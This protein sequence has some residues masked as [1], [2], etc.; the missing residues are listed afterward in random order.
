VTGAGTAY[1]R[2]ES[3]LVI[4]YT[5]DGETLLL[6]RRQP[7]SFW[8]SV[9]GS[10]HYGESYGDAAARELHEE[11]G[12]ADDLCLVPTGVSRTFEID[13]RWSHRYAPG[14]TVNVE[15]EYRCRLAARRTITLCEREHTAAQWLSIGDAIDRVWSWTNKAA[16]E[17]LL[18][19]REGA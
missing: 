2:P 18:E 14:V 7:F 11:T 8:Q 13:P 12:L 9:T 3:V 4:V 19:E 16:L 15:H 6:R 17:A 1:R 5:D 10:L